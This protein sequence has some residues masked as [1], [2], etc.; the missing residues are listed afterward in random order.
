MPPRPINTKR[1]LLRADLPDN[2]THCLYKVAPYRG[3]AH[4]CRYCDGRAEKYYVEGDFENDIDIRVDI[5]TLLSHE[6]PKVRERGIIA[7]GSG[8]TD[9]YQPCEKEACIS[10]R[11]AKLLAES[12]IPIP[13]LVMTK[14]KLILRDIELWQAINKRAGFILLVSLTSLDE[15]LRT[16]MEP[17]AS[18]FGERIETLRQFK[19]AGC[20]TGVLAMPFL[21]G[22]SDSEASIRALYCK[23]HD[24]GVDYVMPGGLTL[25]P[26]RQK[27]L[28]IK[29]LQISHPDLLESTKALFSEGRASGTPHWTARR[30]L[31]SLF[32][33]IQRDFEIP[34]LLP[35][36]IYSKILPVHDTLRILF[37]DMLELYEA[38]GTDTSS[39]VKS[40]KHY[41]TWLI[42]L[43]R[44]FRRK[45]S[46]PDKWLE[47]RFYE[48]SADGE[49]DT[50]L[51]NSK[52][53]AFSHK[54]IYDGAIF[55]YQKLRLEN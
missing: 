50:I 22:L 20:T 55:N 2:F 48:A 43:R 44:Q 38:K 27:D 15:S 13:A 35:H 19:N 53:S 6:L 11:S 23:L 8:T 26:G 21:P 28:Y 46:Y 33:K 16:L 31:H 9:P 36:K 25:R 51:A 47:E 29:T 1:A 54:V 37:R 40:A 45:R 18:S 30:N 12:A 41:D 3:C 52:L 34:W 4:G 39:L 42:E 10:G 24:I 7:F 17:G 49:L 32:R 5:P 14:S